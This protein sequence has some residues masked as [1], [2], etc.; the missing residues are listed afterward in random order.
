MRLSPADPMAADR[1]YD[2]SPPDDT[3]VFIKRLIMKKTLTLLLFSVLLSLKSVAAVPDGAI[4]FIF[5]RHLYLQVTLNDS[6]PVTVVYDTG[7]DFLYLDKDFLKLNDLQDAFGRRGKAKMG[8][9]GNSGPQLTEI[10]ID[11]VRIRC[12]TM[13]YQNKITPIIALRDILGRHTDGLLGNTHL[14]SSPLEISF[15]EGYLKQ[16]EAPFPVDSLEN[17]HK[18]EARFE[19]NRIDVKASLQIDSANAVEGWFRL[20]LGSGSTVSLTN[21]ATSSLHLDDM[22]KAY[23]RTQAGGV[24]GGSEDVEIRAARFCMVDTFENVVID[25]SLNEKGALSS[26]RPYLGI[27][28]N[29]IWSLYDMVL[30]PVSSSVWV[31]RNGKKGT[32]SQSSTTHMAVFDRTD[33]CDGWIVNG[34]YKGGIA[35]QAGIEIGDV[36]IAINDRPVK[37]ISWE[38]QRKG[39]NLRGETKY[40]VRKANGEVV[41]YTL[42]V[43]KQII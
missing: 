28:G 18:L 6:I 7:A 20:D 8:G 13:E 5:D 38:E 43:Q 1:A 36:I 29:D 15:S 26:G 9:A 16:W 21:E 24:G 31:K 41:T 17:Y 42:F 4:P 12:G 3:Q 30:D 23:F 2:I 35:E 25:C 19:G 33:I 22:P 14:L 10:F 27:I 37:E 39:L 34:L 11:P 32:Y 40:T